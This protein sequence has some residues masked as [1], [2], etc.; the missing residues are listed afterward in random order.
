MQP[1]LNPQDFEGAR[2]VSSAKLKEL[3]F[4]PVCMAPG[5]SNPGH[6]HTI[7][8][9]ILVVQSGQGQIQIENKIYDLCAGSVAVVP[10][11]KFHALCNT[12]KENFEGM[13]IFNSN[14]DRKQVV[15][16]SREEHFTK[17]A[18]SKSN[19]LA[20]VQALKKQ[21]KKLKKA[22]KKMR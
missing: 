17:Q 13:T 11:G 22:L 7:V 10:A 16:K 15:L 20:E 6:S 9:E 2:A 3:G 19:L 4:A 14:F 5:E 21:N 18:A 1:V 8:E 12:G